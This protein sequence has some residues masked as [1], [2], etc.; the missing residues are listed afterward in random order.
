METNYLT[1]T[2]VSRSKNGRSKS[3]TYSTV[4]PKVIV[5][6]FKLD[7][8]KKLYWDITDKD[9]ILITPELP[10]EESI[11]A[12]YDILNDILIKGNSSQQ[13]TQ[14]LNTIKSNLETPDETKPMETKITDLVTYYNNLSNQDDKDGF[15]KVLLYLLDY[16]L[17][18]ENQYQIL[19]AVY[20]E[21]TQTD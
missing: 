16:P 6:K 17:G 13:Y 2:K 1:D 7:K 18:M 21:I 9:K 19:K 3:Y 12:G 15:T 14:A 10:E 4:I 11:Q 8:G 5:N 20:Q